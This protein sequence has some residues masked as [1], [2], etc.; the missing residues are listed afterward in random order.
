MAIGGEGQASFF[1]R[2]FEIEKNKFLLGL[3]IVVPEKENL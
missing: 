1:P 3:T 2:H